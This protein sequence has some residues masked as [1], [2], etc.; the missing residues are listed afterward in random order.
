MRRM[1]CI[2]CCILSLAIPVLSQ[3]RSVQP[4]AQAAGRPP[5]QHPVM[6][7]RPYQQ[8]WYDAL[9]K[10]FNPDNL[11]WGHWLEQRRQVFLQ[12]TAANPYFKYS[13]VTTTLLM[14]L[15]MALAKA[16]IDKSRIKWLA[17]D[18]HEDLL[19][20]DR[21]VRQV[22]HRAIRKYNTH[23]EKCNRI[24]ERETV[25]RPSV[26]PA[27]EPAEGTMDLERALEENAQL[28]RERDHLQ[29]ELDGSK[30]RVN[31][32]SKRIDGMAGAGNGSP[33][34]GHAQG[35]A[36]KQINEL[37]EQLYH[38]RARNKQLKGM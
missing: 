7:T 30:A 35:D 32:L 28:R 10:Q 18:R 12:Q 29:V 1:L 3:T 8:P 37:R 33:Q 15:A 11:D 21:Y 14:L 36:V 34:A 19:E 5:Y 20:H 16:E 26:T 22:A 17:Q 2:A 27:P 4:L 25:G 6:V 9:L 23:M 24:V 13:L 38:E 31:D